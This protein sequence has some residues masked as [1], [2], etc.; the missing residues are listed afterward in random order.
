MLKKL[1]KY[2]LEYVYKVLIVFYVLSLFFAV[3]TRILFNIEN[4]FI[5]EIIGK[6]CSGTTIAMMINILINNIMR[7]WA[8]F[9]KNLYGDE[10]YL[11]HTLPIEKKTLYLSKFLSS[12]IT[13][14]TS[15]FIIGLTLFVAYYSKE[16]MELLKNMLLPLANSLDS[17]ML[18]III[19]FLFIFFLQFANTLQAG[20]T[21]LIL[22]HRKNNGK[23]GFSI[24]IGF[25]S[26]ILTQVVAIAFIFL[27]SLF[28]KDLMNLFVTNEM[29]NMDMLKV[30]I[31]L[32]IGVYSIVIIGGYFI[33]LTI[34]KKGVNVD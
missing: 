5:M 20:Y 33:N 29:V 24:V 14:F 13:L 22:G 21:G 25:V 26:Y 8:R 31:Y 15:I 7:L 1:L 34:F 17:S 23:I 10:S 28:N 18:K 2:D 30:I 32:A 19:A 6:I 16:N 3:L 27:I 4:S 12:I 9:Q 11:T